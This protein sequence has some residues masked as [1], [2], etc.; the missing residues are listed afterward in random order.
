M[1]IEYLFNELKKKYPCTTLYIN[2]QYW[3]EISIPERQLKITDIG[4]NFCFI[5]GTIYE[6]AHNTEKFTIV[7]NK[8]DL[9]YK[10]MDVDKKE[11]EE[12]YSLIEEIKYIVSKNSLKLM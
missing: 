7:L 8:K 9:S 5:S 1:K 2:K 4:N 10:T 11:I 3:K 6:T 12:G